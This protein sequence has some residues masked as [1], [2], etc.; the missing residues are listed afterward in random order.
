[1]SK[2]ELLAYDTF[3]MK[4]LNDAINLKQDYDYW[5]LRQ[6]IGVSQMNSDI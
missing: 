1:M 3:Y 2:P 5:R 4:E 6:H